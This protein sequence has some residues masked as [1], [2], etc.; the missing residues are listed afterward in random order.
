MPTSKPVQT[1]EWW[2][3]EFDRPNGFEKMAHRSELS[4]LEFIDKFETLNDPSYG[5]AIAVVHVT[6]EVVTKRS[7]TPIAERTLGTDDVYQEVKRRLLAANGVGAGETALRWAVEQ[8]VEIAR[9]G[10]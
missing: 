7:S 1:T 6:Q 10:D 5:R 3:V 8:A 2:E 4:A 9:S